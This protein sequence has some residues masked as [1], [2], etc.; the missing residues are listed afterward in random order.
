MGGKRASKQE[1]TQLETL[2]KEGLTCREIAQKLGRS[3]AAIRNL[4]YKKHL[5]ARVEDETKVLFQQRDELNKILTKLQGE[6]RVLD[7]KLDYLKTEKERLE[8]AI[9]TD[10]G[11][12][13]ETLTQGLMNL[14]QQRTDLFTLSGPEQIAMLLKAFLK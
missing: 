12:L 5:V 6:K 14:K 1:L 4:R 7:F 10:K 9:R 13:Q 11:L 8:A 2:S 3:P